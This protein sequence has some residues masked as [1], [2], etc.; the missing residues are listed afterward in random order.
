VPPRPR[1]GS[2]PPP[3]VDSPTDRRT[4]SPSRAAGSSEGSSAADGFLAD[5]GPDFDP[6]QTPEA[7]E[8]EIS[9]EQE[10]LEGWSEDTIRSLLTVQGNA[11][12]ALLRVGPDDAD[13]WKH[14]EDDLRAI[15]PPLTRILNRY[16]ATRAAAAAGD[17]IALGAALAAYGAKNYTRRRRLI[18]QLRQQPP[19][20]VSG[21]AADEGTGP[22]HDPEWQRIHEAPPALR[23]KGV[24]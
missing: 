24:R 12:H 16:D 18:V 21:V 11:T 7:P 22:E 10:A 8:P 17:E 6:E 23:P 5:P 19:E 1:N 15:A 20:P 3:D 13:T 4:P 9:P 14:T 2:P